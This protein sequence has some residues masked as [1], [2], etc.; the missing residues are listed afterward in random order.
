MDKIILEE[1]TDEQRINAKFLAQIKYQ[2]K[3]T[4]HKLKDK[5][6][7]DKRKRND[8]YN[9]SVPGYRDN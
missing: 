7:K 2:Q 3:R 9:N 5:K 1:E 8:D 6:H 4:L